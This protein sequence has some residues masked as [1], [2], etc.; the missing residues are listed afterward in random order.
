M[1]YVKIPQGKSSPKD[2]K[3]ILKA[4]NIKLDQFIDDG[5]YISIN[6][7]EEPHEYVIDTDNSVCILAVNP[8]NYV[9]GATHVHESYK[10]YTEGDD[11]N[12]SSKSVL[13]Y[14]EFVNIDVCPG[15]NTNN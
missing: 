14:V 7:E 4:N 11:P 8:L 15:T 5:T 12:A 10:D 3:D 1:R 2:I 6:L 9:A 13:N